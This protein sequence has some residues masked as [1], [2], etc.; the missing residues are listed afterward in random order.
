MKE[1]VYNSLDFTIIIVNL[2]SLAALLGAISYSKPTV[3]L[4]S[5]AVLC[6]SSFLMAC[7]NDI[8]KKYK[9]NIFDLSDIFIVII[10]CMGIAII[11]I[12]LYNFLLLDYN[13]FLSN[14]LPL[15]RLFLFTLIF[16][17]FELS[18]LITRA[19]KYFQKTPYSIFKLIVIILLSIL[20]ITTLYKLVF[21]F[22]SINKR[23]I[24]PKFQISQSALL[25]RREMQTINWRY[26]NVR[27][28][29]N[30]GLLLQIQKEE[31]LSEIADL[32]S[33]KPAESL[34][35]L[36]KIKLN[37]EKEKGGYYELY[38]IYNNNNL[39]NGK[40]SILSIE[41]LDNGIVILKGD[42]QL[43]SLATLEGTSNY[44][45]SKNINDD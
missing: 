8:I 17:G 9:P 34:T 1:K 40:G 26:G 21:E 22:Y 20:T 38:F 27:S 42:K 33:N 10:H 11:T 23:Y 2:L 13:N 35:T 24:L 41:I 37:Y 25:G 7:I 3:I 28:L 16:L 43:H 39:T 31:T 32:L 29:Q 14:E 4:V 15:N 45:V 30:T 12:F 44:K 18:I 6:I 36:K 5:L 19:L